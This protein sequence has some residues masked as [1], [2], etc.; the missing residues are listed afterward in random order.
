MQLA[1]KCEGKQSAL[2]GWPRRPGQLPVTDLA[3]SVHLPKFMDLTVVPS[4]IALVDTH[5]SHLMWC[6]EQTARELIK[7]RK[8]RLIRKNGYP[9]ML[10]ASQG[11][12][13]FGSL[14]GGRGTALD[15]TR[16]SHNRETRDNPE[17]V[18]TLKR[19]PAATR[20]IYTAVLDGCRAA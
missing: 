3:P 13:E 5:G 16:Y 20:S 10:I 8:A 19:L 14:T 18:W 6:D 17:G 9:R 1:E 12:R 7:A 4:R 15:K 2:G 11:Q